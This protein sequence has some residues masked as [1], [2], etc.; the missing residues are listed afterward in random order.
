MHADNSLDFISACEDSC[1]YPPETNGIAENAFRR[2]KDGA[3]TLVVQSGRS[4]KWWGEVMK[5]FCCLRNVQDKLGDQKL[6][7]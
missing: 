7:F 3:S 2:I 4:E 6:P 5:R 1:S